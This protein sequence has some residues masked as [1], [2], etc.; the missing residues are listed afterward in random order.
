LR[1]LYTVTGTASLLRNCDPEIGALGCPEEAGRNPAGLAR[2]A[3]QAPADLPRAL[4]R[5]ITQGAPERPKT[6]P[7]GAERDIG[8]RGVAVTQQRNR[9]LDAAREQVAVRRDAEGLPEQ[10]RE[11][12]LGEAADARQ[13]LHGPRLVRGGVHPIPHAQQAPQHLG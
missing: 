11:V 6:R 9:P 1:S 12:G 4:A 7:A 13:P 5:H 8:D 10:A 2:D 3:P